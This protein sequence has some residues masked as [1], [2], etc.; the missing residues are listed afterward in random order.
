MK[1]KLLPFIWKGNLVPLY[2]IVLI[3]ITAIGTYFVIPFLAIYLTRSIHISPSLIGILFSINWVVSRGLM[4]FTG[5]L[6]DKYGAKKFVIL[7]LAL[8]G[9][10]YAG[11]TMA[12]DYILLIIVFVISGIGIALFQP[13]SKSLL[14]VFT[15]PESRMAI[16]A[17][18]NTGFNSGVALGSWLGAFLANYFSIN[19][20]FL[21]AAGIYLMMI[22]LSIFLIPPE[23]VSFSQSVSFFKNLRITFQHRELMILTISSVGFW[24]LF[25]QLNV[26]VPLAVH[27]LK[28]DMWISWVFGINAV[29]TILLQIPLNHIAKQLGLSPQQQMF[30]GLLLMGMS[31]LLI[32]FLQ[33]GLVFLL[34]FTICFTIGEILVAPHFDTIASLLADK[35]NVGTFLGV[36]SIG[37][38]IGGG[39]G[40]I[41]GGSLLDFGRNIGIN[42]LIWIVCMITAIIS[43]ILLAKQ[44]IVKTK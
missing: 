35:Q 31:F 43:S 34:L 7:G 25:T 15:L 42:Q 39:L 21:V 20:L 9:T 11:Y 40:G 33:L 41:V 5:I 6:S 22:I 10:S 30:Y 14:A 26:T 27:D 29:L 12:K 24:A 44:P 1:I 8:I 28:M 32:A 13:A 37:W 17:W 3:F 19:K 23:K 36:S 18:R 4:V 16:F 38:A 2:L